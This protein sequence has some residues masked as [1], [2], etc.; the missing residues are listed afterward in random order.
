MYQSARAQQFTETAGCGVRGVGC[1]EVRSASAAVRRRRIHLKT[2]APV[3]QTDEEQRTQKHRPT[4]NTHK[5]TI[6]SIKNPK[7][8]SSR[9]IRSTDNDMKRVYNEFTADEVNR[10][11]GVKIG[12]YG[13]GARTYTR[14]ERREAPMRLTEEQQR[15]NR[16]LAT[17]CCGFVTVIVLIYVE[18]M[19]A[20]VLGTFSEASGAFS[21]GLQPKLVWWCE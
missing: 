3:Q 5:I 1:G 17:G 6:V 12:D 9:Q 16:N 19:L 21:Y 8:L 11:T 4:V 18:R 10:G 7:L 15:R 13:T 20:L 2:V 14:Y